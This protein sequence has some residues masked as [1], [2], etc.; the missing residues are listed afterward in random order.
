MYILHSWPDTASLIMDLVLKEMDLPYQS[1]QID[2]PAGALDSPEYRALHPLGLIPA[3][4]T[5]DGPMFETAAMLLYLSEQHGLAP[6]PGTP[7]RAA[8]LKWL[9][10]TSTNL[11]PTLLQTFYPARTADDTASVVAHARAKLTVYLKL[12]DDL[13]ESRPSFLSDTQPTVLGYYIAVLMRW[14]S[15][16]FPSTDYPALHRVLAYLETRPAT[17]ACAAA[18]GLGPH[19]FTQG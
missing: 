2:R 4:E 13:A 5:P 3:L 9:F 18:N 10:F 12:L 17:L 19:P 6:A 15:T 11:H 16:D 14:L 1:R 8:F 7:D